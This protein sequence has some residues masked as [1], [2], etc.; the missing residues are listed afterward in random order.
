LHYYTGRDDMVVGVDVANRTRTETEELIGFFVNQL[1]L[2]TDLSGN[3]SFREV[4]RRVRD[5]SLEAY[6]YQDLPFDRLVEAL[7]PQRDLSR[8][9]LFQVMFGLQNVPIPT[10]DLPGVQLSGMEIPVTQAVFDLT[11]YM[12]DT[13][14]GVFGSLR[15]N[16][17]LFEPPTISRM[18]KLF[19]TLLES[20]V[21]KPNLTLSELEDGLSR[22]ER[23]HGIEQQKQV[24]Q[25]SIKKLKSVKRKAVNV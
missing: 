16:A 14:Q 15:Y 23:Q 24:E 8:N 11:L 9:P 7:N 13:A 5:V 18:A 21:A 22:F 3:P 6:A 2:R 17:E 25:V 4:L 1:V 10:L 19:E 20:I 12:T